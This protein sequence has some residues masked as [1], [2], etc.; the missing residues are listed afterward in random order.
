MILYNQ[1]HNKLHELFWKKIDYSEKHTDKSLERLKIEK[2]IV[3][4]KKNREYRFSALYSITVTGAFIGSCILPILI[5]LTIVAGI[6]A[7]ES[8]HKY[9]DQEDEIKE[10]DKRINTFI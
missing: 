4:E 6:S 10:L 3:N 7:S 9:L 5:P 1:N 8:I 2:Y